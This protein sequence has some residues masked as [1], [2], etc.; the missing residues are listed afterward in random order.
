[1]IQSSYSWL[2]KRSIGAYEGLQRA[3]EVDPYPQAYSRLN[4]DAL[5]T[6]ASMVSFDSKLIDTPPVHMM[7][8]D[9]PMPHKGPVSEL[10][11]GM[12][13]D[14]VT[15]HDKGD[16]NDGEGGAPSHVPDVDDDVPHPTAVT[17]QDTLISTC[18]GVTS[19]MPVVAIDSS[20]LTRSPSSELLFQLKQELEALKR[21]HASQLASLQNQHDNSSSST[22]YLS[23]E[24]E[25]PE[26]AT[27]AA[28]LG[29]SFVIEEEDL[30][31]ANS[32]LPY[33][34]G[35]P[36]RSIYSIRSTSSLPCPSALAAGSGILDK[37]VHAVIAPAAVI[38]NNEVLGSSGD[39][40][41]IS[42]EC[43][44]FT[45]ISCILSISFLE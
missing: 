21:E 36:L 13:Q 20:T 14:I 41:P 26:H 10:L 5:S 28:L 32:Q 6:T 25:Q 11:D 30:L 24:P 7:A 15:G 34:L 42:C 38:T 45:F 3:T 37:S 2:R 31:A 17:P 43:V 22:Q 23:P 12:P 44:V 4:G 29:E 33:Y 35:P 18:A 40:E 1:M 16:N 39:H 9:K 27:C 8:S 19:V